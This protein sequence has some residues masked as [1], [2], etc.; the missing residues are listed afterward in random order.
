MEYIWSKLFSKSMEMRKKL[1]LHSI[2]FLFGI[3]EISYFCMACKYLLVMVIFHSYLWADSD[4]AL[5][6]VFSHIPFYL[7]SGSSNSGSEKV[8]KPYGIP[9]VAPVL[10][11]VLVR[12]S[13]IEKI[14]HVMRSPMIRSEE[15]LPSVLSCTLSPASEAHQDTG[16][17]KAFR[18]SSEDDIE[19]K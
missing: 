8:W 15:L 16:T 3:M 11:N 7:F 13:D 9:L 2:F 17:N 1:N 18:N 12:N 19:N 10:R 14:V 4:H 5:L 6:A